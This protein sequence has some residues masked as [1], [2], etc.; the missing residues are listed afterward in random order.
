MADQK[1]ADRRH[2]RLIS[3]APTNPQFRC[4]ETEKEFAPKHAGM[5]PHPFCVRRLQTLRSDILAHACYNQ[6]SL[7]K[8]D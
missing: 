7:K 4:R 1:V 6:Y 5:S 8:L 2:H 3:C